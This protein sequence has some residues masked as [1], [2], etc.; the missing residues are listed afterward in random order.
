MFPCKESRSIG[1][2]SDSLCSSS[3]TCTPRLQFGWNITGQNV[4]DC[5]ILDSLDGFLCSILQHFQHLLSR[6]GFGSHSQHGISGHQHSLQRFCDFFRSGNKVEVEG[7]L[8]TELVPLRE[9]N[10]RD[11]HGNDSDNGLTQNR[12]RRREFGLVNDPR[13]LFV[14]RFESDRIGLLHLFLGHVIGRIVHHGREVL[15]RAPGCL[16]RDFRQVQSLDLRLVQ[17]VRELIRAGSGSGAYQALSLFDRFLQSRGLVR[18]DFF[19]RSLFQPN[20]CRSLLDRVSVSAYVIDIVGGS[21][22][23]IS[24]FCEFFR[25]IFVRGGF[26]SLLERGSLHVGSVFLFLIPLRKQFAA[27]AA[28]ASCCLDCLL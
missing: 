14:P 6:H 20:G 27:A 11:N 18:S 17:H 21:G 13:Y 9:N 2:V 8:P 1:S 25:V 7:G 15:V 22:I 26:S 12:K 4:F 5:S 16:A 19:R 10:R 24:H 3:A 23:K 28:T